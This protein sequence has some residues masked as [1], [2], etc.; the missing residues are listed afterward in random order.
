M[1][2]FDIVLDHSLYAVPILL[3]ADWCLQSVDVSDSRLQVQVFSMVAADER[4]PLLS[5]TAP[6]NPSVTSPHPCE[7]VVVGAL[8]DS[9]TTGTNVEAGTLIEAS[10]V[11][12]WPS[13]AWSIGG[14]VRDNSCSA[15]TWLGGSYLDNGACD[16]PYQTEWCM[17]GTDCADCGNC[18]GPSVAAVRTIPNMLKESCG[19]MPAGAS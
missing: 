6:T 12:E 11:P 5:W 9:L 16:E 14:A 10:S 1:R 13:H 15:S 3:G 2:N 8:G 17:T 18:P 4:C 19:S 7:I